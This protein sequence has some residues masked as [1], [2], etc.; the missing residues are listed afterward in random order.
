MD[1]SRV[2]M[3]TAVLQKRAG[4]PVGMLDSYLS[5][6]GGM[7][8]TDPSSDLAVA[9]AMTSAV[10]GRPLPATAVVFGEVGLAG[11][12]RRVT[13]MQRR[14]AEAARLGFTAAVVPAGCGAAPEG[15]RTLESATVND[16]LRA[17]LAISHPAAG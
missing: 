13:G 3:I 5:T 14:L 10:T 12:V 6:V 4:V 11:D 17:V 2:A 15:L 8:L 1:Q 16:A 7:R 9:A